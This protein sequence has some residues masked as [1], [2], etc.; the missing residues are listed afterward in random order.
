MKIACVIHS[1]SGGG[2]ERVMASLASRLCQR[3]HRVLLI[4]LDDASD[5]RYELDRGVA[6]HALDLMSHSRTLS[7]QLTNTYR[8]V[9]ALRRA[10]RQEAPDVVLSFCDTTNILT[11]A[12]T[13]RLD[14]PVVVSERSDPVQQ[15]LSD[16]WER[17][18]RWLYPRAARLIALSETSAAGLQPLSRRTVRV[19]PSAV[20]VPPQP[21]DRQRAEARRRIVGIGRLEYEK[22]FDR[23]IE[24]FAAAA[25]QDASWTLRLVGEGSQRAELK[26]LAARLGVAERV[27]MPGWVRPIWG[28]LAEATCFALPSRHEGFPSALLEAMAMGVPSV[29]VDCESGPRAILRHEHDGLLVPDSVAGLSDG[30]RRL[31]GDADLRERLGAAAVNVVDRFS[32]EAMVDAYEDVLRRAVS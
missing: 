8:R 10:I 2:A 12:A 18:R 13:R 24:A 20:E 25:D 1:L 22:G 17:L 26:A 15:R 21:R 29:A 19:I 3:G 30:L 4:T 23:L 16:G 14:V 32:W 27:S 31:T 6:R 5:D 11:L 7:E 9:T 28:E